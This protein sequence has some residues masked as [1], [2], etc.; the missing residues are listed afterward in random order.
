WE[1]TPTG[2]GHGVGFG[3]LPAVNRW[4]VVFRRTDSPAKEYR[5]HVSA[6]GPDSITVPAL[7][8][9]LDE[10]L[11]RQAIEG[12]RYIYRPA[13]A[14]ARDTGIP[15]EKVRRILETS[16]DFIEGPRPNA[17]G[18]TLYSTRDH[19][20]KHAGFVQRYLDTLESS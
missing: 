6:S 7:I 14:I 10:A 1:A 5:A 16:D 11:V 20:R 9:A 13:E 8:D 12:S 15:L 17:Q 4:G 18:Y 19:Y 2:M 3:H